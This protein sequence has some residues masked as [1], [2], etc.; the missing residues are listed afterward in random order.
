MPHDP[1]PP[2]QP[3]Q[4]QQQNQQPH[5]QPHRPRHHQPQQGGQQRRPP[6]PPP[7]PKGVLIWGDP[8]DPV[9]YSLFTRCQEA[10]ETV[11]WHNEAN[12]FR[13]NQTPKYEVLINTHPDLASVSDFD[14]SYHLS[15]FMG[16][17]SLCFTLCLTQCGRDQAHGFDKPAQV[18]GFSAVSLYRDTPVVELAT[19]ADQTEALLQRAEAFLSKL[20]LK[21]IRVPE[22]PALILGRTIAMLV[23]EAASALM[24]GIAT[25]GDL[26]TAMATGVNYPEGPLHW[27]DL[28]GLDTIL[29]ILLHLYDETHEERYRPVPLLKDKVAAGETGFQNGRG[30]FDYDDDPKPAP[31]V[32]EPAHG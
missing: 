6:G 30:F 21:S 27:A 1:Q 17:D 28:I 31:P 20:N 10:G 29:A 7:P 32:A 5:Q 2:S 12:S 9:A 13:P 16:P 22:I 14:L 25:P 11:S 3:A 15:D 4:P 23:N 18:F 19:R 24:E 26:D 8:E